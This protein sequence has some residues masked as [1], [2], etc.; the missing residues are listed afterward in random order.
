M[1][2]KRQVD[3]S[4]IERA[5]T[6][7]EKES[8]QDKRKSAAAPSILGWRV[9]DD[10]R[11]PYA[12]PF[13]ELSADEEKVVGELLEELREAAKKQEMEDREEVEARAKAL[14]MQRCVAERIFMEKDQF[15]YLVRAAVMTAHGFGVLDLLLADEEL[16]EIAVIGLGKP[17]YVYHRTRG[18]LQ[19]NARIDSEEHAL[20]VINKMARPLGRRITLASPRLNAVLPNGSR[21]HASIPPVSGVEMTIRKFRS[22]PISIPELISF[23]TFSPASLA[24]LWA[25]LEHDVSLLIAG[26]TAS[27][28]TSTLN[29]LFSFIPLADRVLVTEDAPEINIPHPH[30]VKLLANP[31]LGVPLRELVAD[32]IRMRP[33]RVIVGEVRS[34]EEV[35]A[36]VETLLSGQARGC[37]AT[38]HADSGEEAMTRLRFSGASAADLR[39]IDAILVQRRMLRRAG[40]RLVEVRRAVEITEVVPSG[41]GFRLNRVFSY[42]ARKDELAR[43]HPSYLAKSIAASLGEPESA[44]WARVRNR[45]AFLASLAR[46]AGSL[47]FAETVERIQAFRESESA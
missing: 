36:L 32:C 37:Y 47:R 35:G 16:E 28:K 9:F 27:G 21:L 20:A 11:A 3:L 38:F 7:E 2:G 42:D 6:G 17:V 1:S 29:A 23:Q 34:A 30:A 5:I 25:A 39:S 26:N 12:V 14:L 4:E 44:F 41:E 43:V 31:E 45:T 18:W 10:G 13:P 33:D 46:Q 19:T 8:P 40:K 22:N 24:F 15:D